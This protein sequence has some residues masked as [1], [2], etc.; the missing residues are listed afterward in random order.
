M[1]LHTF[2]LVFLAEMADKTQLMVM[3]LTNRYKTRTVLFGMIS[4]VLM[5]SGLSVLAGDIIGDV[6]PMQVIELCAA[7]LF[8]IFGL[9]NLRVSPQEKDKNYNFRFPIL[10]IAFTFLLAELGDKTQVATVALAADHMQ[11]HFW[12]FLG[13]SLGLIFANVFGI[14][15]GKF[16]FSHFSEDSVKVVSSFIFFLFGSINLFEVLPYN[17]VYISIYSFLLMLLAYIVFIR[18]RKQRF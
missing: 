5:I 2:L 11:E 7:T 18:S 1:F 16:I 4:G 12:I 3:A 15:A 13:A 8:L 17:I 9:S 10:S 6:I 14:F